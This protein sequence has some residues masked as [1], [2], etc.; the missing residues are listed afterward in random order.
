MT[1]VSDL[2]RAI[3]EHGSV[4]VAVIARAAGST[5]RDAGC[6]M[7]VHAGGTTGTIGGG[8]VEH[9]VIT[10]AHRMIADAARDP[11]VI[12]RSLGPQIDQ[13]CGGNMHIVLRLFDAGD[14]NQID[15]ARVPL[16]PGGPYLCSSA[17]PRPVLIYGGGHVGRAL[18]SALAPLPFATTLIDS[19]A[20]MDAPDVVLTPLP[21]ALAEAASPEALHVVMSHSH[22]LDLEIVTTVLQRA[23]GFCGLIGSA[24]K[25]AFF[26][27]RL[28]ERGLSADQI[29]GLTCPIGA[30][31]LRNKHPSVIA[32]ATAVQLLQRDAALAAAD[33]ASETSAAG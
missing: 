2:R 33:A 19:R 1:S 28:R 25:R 10:Q 4:V 21:E 3:A 6:A 20:E 31:G 8:A 16:T 32:A 13:C 23:H 9:D 30:G 24:T 11:Q 15:S 22:A 12:D 5:P 17:A 26:A 27:R 7:L 14:V 18:A 29:A